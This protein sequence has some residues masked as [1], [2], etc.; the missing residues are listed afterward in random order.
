MVVPCALWKER[1]GRAR[2]GLR[3]KQKEDKSCLSA[4]ILGRQLNHKDGAAG[5]MSCVRDV[6]LIPAVKS[7]KHFQARILNK[8]NS[9]QG[10]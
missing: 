3:E 1:A 7:P 6:F 10:L 9:P 2:L 8:K 4:L 5:G